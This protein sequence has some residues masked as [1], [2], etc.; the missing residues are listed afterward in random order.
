MKKFQ[1]LKANN[2]SK[3]R[4]INAADI[5]IALLNADKNNQTT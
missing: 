1:I 3:N 2:F 4:V 5:D